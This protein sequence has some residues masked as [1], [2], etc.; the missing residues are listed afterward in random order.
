MDK[1]QNILNVLS[2]LNDE[3]LRCLKHI[4]SL[5]SKIKF[6]IA[7]TI[8][9]DPP[10]G[11]Y[12]PQRMCQYFDHNT[13]K[14]FPGIR[15]MNVDGYFLMKDTLIGEDIGCFLEF[16]VDNDS[17]TFEDFDGSKECMML[18]RIIDKNTITNDFAVYAVHNVSYEIPVGLKD[19]IIKGIYIK[20][21]PSNPKGKWSHKY[22]NVTLLDLLVYICMKNKQGT[23]LN[24]NV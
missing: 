17:N 18:Q 24:K 4:E 5:P 19:L 8:L 11:I 6:D 13:L 15:F 20:S 10:E 23:M 12:F 16:K 14:S 7:T 9:M 2:Q 3:D 1:Q 22:D 21:N